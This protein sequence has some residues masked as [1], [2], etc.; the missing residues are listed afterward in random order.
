M[1]RFTRVTL[2]VAAL[3]LFAA[4]PARANG[5]FPATMSVHSQDANDQRLLVGTTFGLLISDDDGDTWHWVCEQN[6]GYSGTWD[7][8]YAIS[9]AGTFFASTPSG[10]SVSRDR[11]CSW[12]FA[13]PPMQDQW[14]SDVQ[15][16]SDGAVWVSTASSGFANDVYVSRDDGMTFTSTGLL[17]SLAWWKSLRIAPSDPLRIYVSGYQLDG[18]A[19]GGDG[20]PAPLLYRSDDG[21]MGWIEIPFA[22]MGQSQLFIVGVSPSDPNLVF[23]RLDGSPGDELLRSD[24]GGVAWTPVASFDDDLL[25]FVARA[26]SETVIAGSNVNLTDP[27]H[28]DVRVSTDSG[29]TFTQT[30]WTEAHNVPKMGCLNE[31]SDGELFSCGANWTPDRMALGRSADGLSWSKVMRFCEIDGMLECPAGSPQMNLCGPLWPALAD[32]FGIP[33]AP[34]A[35]PSVDAGSRPDAG[36]GGG[37]PDCGCR[38]GRGGSAGGAIALLTLAAAWLR[39]RRI[40]R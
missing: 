12:I 23:A 40:R 13:P 29:A 15:V 30:T 31:R 19:D 27:V 22:M 5:R 17:V 1:C 21:G 10:L 18:P 35:G 38:L 34:D 25:G 32:Q 11:G 36:N 8:I 2:A 28:G 16:A 9:H 3:S 14:I 26:G 24:D 20:V 37:S 39:R 33:C 6:I 7:P 4:G